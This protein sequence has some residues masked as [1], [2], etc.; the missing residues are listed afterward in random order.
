MQEYLTDMCSLC[1]DVGPVQPADYARNR[2]HPRPGVT[3]AA[4]RGPAV[5]RDLPARE[6]ERV[7]RRV[8][9]KFTVLTHMD[10][11]AEIKDL[12]PSM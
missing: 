3:P 12:P 1:A 8:E 5:A 9:Q 2:R 6:A 7:L 4:A 11:M 10:P